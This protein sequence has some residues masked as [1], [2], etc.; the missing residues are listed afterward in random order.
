[1]KFVSLTRLLMAVFLAVVIWGYV[2]FTQNP[3]LEVTFNV[4][5]RTRNMPSK[6]LYLNPSLP[7]VEIKIKG[8]RDKVNL[9]SQNSLEP[10]VDMS[11][12][13]KAGQQ[14]FNVLLNE[15]DGTRASITPNTVVFSI[16][17][18]INR[19]FPL[20][21]VRRGAIGSQLDVG[22]V[23]ANV[24]EVYVS[25]PQSSVDRVRRIVAIYDA[26]KFDVGTSEQEITP[27]L[28]GD[29]DQVISLQTGSPAELTIRPETVVIR[30][31]VESLLRS[32]TVPV[33]VTQKGEPAA[34]YIA[35][36]VTKNPAV[37]TISSFDR[38]VIEGSNAVDFVETEPV[39]ISGATE[40]IT[41]TTKL[42]PKGNYTI[43]TPLEVRVTIDI[44][45][46]QATSSLIVPVKIEGLGSNLILDVSNSSVLVVLNGPL[47]DLQ[48]IN[49]DQIEAKVDLRGQDA[50]ELRVPVQIATPTGITVTNNP[51]IMVRLTR[52]P[53]PTPIPPTVTP[54]PSVTPT[55]PTV[56]PTTLPITP[57]PNV[58][59]TP[60]TG[61]RNEPVTT[62]S[63]T[64]AAGTGASL[65]APPLTP[66][67][68][69]EIT[70]TVATSTTPRPT[71]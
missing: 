48:K 59:E 60:S 54:T 14:S 35:G 27:T 41:T 19:R 53:T 37:V 47:L 68:P 52:R 55:A 44:A 30:A 64:G 16:D 45:P 57:T 36:Y 6:F 10:Y 34:G 17:E 63:P 23:T 12:I 2:T 61:A 5:V 18:R 22:V 13:N 25:G 42:I 31:T 11:G 65:P 1:M 70:P 49:L 40:K 51:S 39:D 4:E 24:T 67:P 15:P 62:P 20:E 28:Y 38:S 66:S 71:P 29:N 43:N 50:G 32:K 26:T 3:E 58:T 33:V 56:A 7:K 21:L 69:A 9:V 8:S 46:A